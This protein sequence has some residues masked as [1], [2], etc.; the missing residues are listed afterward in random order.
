M[1][2]DQS[3][4]ST[5]HPLLGLVLTKSSPRS[6]RRE[7]SI[8]FLAVPKTRS[9]PSLVRALTSPMSLRF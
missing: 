4:S 5:F 1:K 9:I 8:V 7:P 2:R 3:N 6:V